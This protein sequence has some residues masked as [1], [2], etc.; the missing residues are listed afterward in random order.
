VTSEA[1]YVALCCSA[2]VPDNT[3]QHHSTGLVTSEAL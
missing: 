1:L 3:V 2:A